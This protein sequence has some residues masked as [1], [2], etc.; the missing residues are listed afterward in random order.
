[1]QCIEERGDVVAG[2]GSAVAAHQPSADAKD[3]RR[4][5][6]EL[7]IARPAPRHIDEQ[8]LQRISARHLGRRPRRATSRRRRFALVEL[9]DELFE[10]GIGDE[11]RHTSE[12]ERSMPE[13]TSS[14]Y[15][16]ASA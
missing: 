7:Q 5:G 2:E 4:P 1:M 15:P 8:R 12:Y 10:L 6:D 16:R 9:A 14:A 11:S 3:R 13:V